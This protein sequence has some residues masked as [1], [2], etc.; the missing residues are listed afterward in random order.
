MV[1]KIGKLVTLFIL[2]F[3][4]GFSQIGYFENNPVWRIQSRCASGGPS[5][6]ITS[7]YNYF[8]K[9]DTVMNSHIYKRLFKVG[10]GYYTWYSPSP[11][12]PGCI[13]SFVIGDTVTPFAFIRDTLSKIYLY[14]SPEKCIY[15]FNLNVGDTLPMACYGYN[16]HVVQS[17]DTVII[18]NSIRRRFHLTG[19]LAT[20]LIEGM[21]HEYG[22]LELMPPILECSNILQCYS[23]S[24]TSYFPGL[25]ISCQSFNGIESIENHFD[26]YPQPASDYVVVSSSKFNIGDIGVYSLSGFLVKNLHFSDVRSLILDLSDLSNGIYFLDLRTKEYR[27]IR[28]VV[29]CR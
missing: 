28:K 9:G 19:G 2:L 21:G 24:D 12:D 27:T 5:C 22:F 3:N 4:T 17:I 26:I 11:V 8:L 18:A 20:I 25:N 13:G 6:V 23:V 16:E 14:G 15:D 7:N 10:F 1:F 29:L